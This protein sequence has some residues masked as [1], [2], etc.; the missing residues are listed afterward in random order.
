MLSVTLPFT[1]RAKYPPITTLFRIFFHGGLLLLVDRKLGVQEE[2]CTQWESIREFDVPTET[3]ITMQQKALGIR[4]LGLD[5]SVGRLY[6]F[7]RNNREG[8][9]LLAI[10]ALSFVISA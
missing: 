8:R 3:F 7:C 10:G 1:E 4:S 9:I 6:F 2:P 5:L